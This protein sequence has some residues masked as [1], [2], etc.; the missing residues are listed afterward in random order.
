MQTSGSISHSQGV[1]KPHLTQVCLTPRPCAF[2]LKN[3]P[4]YSF[5][6]LHIRREC[7]CSLRN[8]VEMIFYKSLFFFLAALCSMQDLHSST[9]DLTCTSH[10]GSRESSLLE[11]QGRPHTP[12]LDAPSSEVSEAGSAVF[13]TWFDPVFLEWLTGNTL[14]TCEW[15]DPGTKVELLQPFIQDFQ[16]QLYNSTKSIRSLKRMR[17]LVPNANCW[18]GQEKQQVI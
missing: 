6:N 14:S 11:H 9:R 3:C 5:M 2:H 1:I 4:L 7:D 13:H 16:L 18:S 15:S 12:V 10:G 17:D 8:N